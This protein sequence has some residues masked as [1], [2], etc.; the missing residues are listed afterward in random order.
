[1]AAHRVLVVAGTDGTISGTLPRTSSVLIAD[2]DALVVRAWGLRPVG[3]RGHDGDD[4]DLDE[5]IVEFVR[6]E[7]IQA[8]V[9]ASV[10]CELR[11]MLD[12][13]RIPVFER[14]GIS[15]C[16]AAVSAAAVLLFMESTARGASSTRRYAEWACREE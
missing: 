13:R 3:W 9:A 1:M 8:V 4:R 2:V 7:G 14:R 16:A 12:A 11:H 6:G 15:A 10:T 5:R